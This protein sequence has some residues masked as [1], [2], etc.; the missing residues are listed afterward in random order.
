MLIPPGRNPDASVIILEEHCAS[1][2][3]SVSFPLTPALSLGERERAL[4]RRVQT[5][6]RRGT[7]HDL[8]VSRNPFSPLENS[9]A[10]RSVPLFAPPGHFIYAK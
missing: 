2:M 5:G 3:N 8:R 10:T 1:V 6:A 4:A 7:E 9:L